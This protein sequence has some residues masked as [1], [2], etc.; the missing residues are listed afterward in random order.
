MQSIK[1]AFGCAPATEI[2]EIYITIEQ[3][4]SIH[5]ICFRSI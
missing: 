1:N 2:V 3:F 4:N 5:N